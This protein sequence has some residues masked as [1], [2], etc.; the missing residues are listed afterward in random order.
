MSLAKDG[1]PVLRSAWKEPEAELPFKAEH[2][3]PAEESVP[4]SRTSMIN[5]AEEVG[6]CFRASIAFLNLNSRAVLLAP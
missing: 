2:Q 1:L 3:L 5:P 4:D 6:F